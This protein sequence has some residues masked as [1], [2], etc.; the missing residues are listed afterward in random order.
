MLKWTGLVGLVAVALLSG[1]APGPMM[2]AHVSAVVVEKIGP[3]DSVDY[4]MVRAV[5]QGD[6]PRVVAFSLKED[7]A[8]PLAYIWDNVHVGSNVAFVYFAPNGDPKYPPD[9]IFALTTADIALLD[10]PD[11]LEEVISLARERK[12]ATLLQVQQQRD[13][14]NKMWHQAHAPKE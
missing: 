13:A 3:N 4:G 11:D 8:R 1:C 6:E 5:I 10:K 9:N 7:P 2:D 14:L 12:R